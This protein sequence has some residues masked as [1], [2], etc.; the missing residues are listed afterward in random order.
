MPPDVESQAG[1][2]PSRLIAR[3][4]IEGLPQ[5]GFVPFGVW[6]KTG[7]RGTA[8]VIGIFQALFSNRPSRNLR[9]AAVQVR[10]ENVA[11]MTDGWQRIYRSPL[12]QQECGE[13][14]QDG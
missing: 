2:T 3:N 5:S 11:G 8:F 12:V 13:T 1:A 10:S 7:G 14:Y 4:R 9:V 6:I